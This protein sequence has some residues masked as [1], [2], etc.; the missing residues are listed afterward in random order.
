MGDRYQL[1]N[2][3]L[4]MLRILVNKFNAAGTT[5][6]KAVL[7][8]IINYIVD[9]YRQVLLAPHKRMDIVLGALRSDGKA[10]VDVD[11]NPQGTAIID[12]E[13]PVKKV[14][15]ALGDKAKFISYLKAK[16]EDFRTT[17]GAFVV[18]EMSRKTFN[19][20]IVGSEEFGDFYKMIFSQREV[21]VSTG[22]ITSDMASQVFTGIGLP[23]IRIVEDLV[24]LPDGTNVQTFKDNRISLF[25]STNLGRMMWHT[26]YEVTDPVPNKTYVQSAGGMYISSF[27]TDEGRFMEYGAEWIP[28]ITSPQK[29]V[30]FDLDTMNP[31]L[32]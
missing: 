5:G 29:L 23:P 16:I 22:L 17:I 19:Q 6:Q 4:D 20:C 32:P 7:D 31:A 1:D 14:A 11:T 13:L 8:E 12:I 21:S 25:S 28:N 3:R 2:D 18:M 27:R 30:I 10:E 15:P 26:P 24:A 9:D